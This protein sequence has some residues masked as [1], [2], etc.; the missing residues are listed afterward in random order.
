M[1]RIHTAEMLGPF[2]SDRRRA[3]PNCP[4]LSPSYVPPVITATRPAMIQILDCQSMWHIFVDGN[5]HT[6][7]GAI[8]RLYAKLYAHLH[9]LR[10]AA[11]KAEQFWNSFWQREVMIVKTNI[12]ARITNRF[13]SLH[14]DV[15]STH[16]SLSKH[17]SR[18]RGVVF[19][20]VGWRESV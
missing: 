12:S 13:S 14:A 6:M 18:F 15:V 2:P 19:V 7:T 5:V 10:R 8:W 11:A 9:G 20:H 16:S 1:I 3:V 17:A 4:Q